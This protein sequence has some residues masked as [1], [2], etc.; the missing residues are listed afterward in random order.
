MGKAKNKITHWSQYNQALIKRGAVTF[1]IDD[2]VIDAW[3]CSQHHGR[4]GRG[5]EFTEVAIE[6]A[7]IVKGVFS[8]PLRALQG[9]IDSIFTLMD[10]PLRSLNDSSISKRSY[11]VKSLW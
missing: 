4:R 5:F 6:N 3:H 10:V 9:F 2:P 1:W 11:G 7:L 8:L